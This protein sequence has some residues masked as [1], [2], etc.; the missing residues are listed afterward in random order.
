M[1]SARKPDED[2]KGPLKAKGST[3][4]KQISK[5]RVFRSNCTNSIL[6]RDVQEHLGS[7]I[8]TRAVPALYTVVF[9]LGLPANGLA[10]WVLLFRT[11][12]MPSTMLLVNLVAADLLFML[13]LPFKIT[14]H[15]MENNWIFGEALCRIITAVFYLNMYC[16]VLFLTA[17][18]IDR[19]IGL[20]HPFH[21]KGLRDWRRSTCA[22][23]GIWLVAIAAATVFCLVP[24]TKCFQKPF[25]ITCHEIWASCGGY[26][27][28]TGYF[29]GLSTVGFAI[30]SVAIVF[31]YV[32]ILVS[33]AKK[34]NSYR[35]LIGLIS[36]VLLTFVLCFTPSNVLLFL[37][38]LETSWERHN[39]LYLWY[40]VALSLTSLNSCIDPFIYC[41]ASNDFWTALKGTLCITKEGSGMSSQ[42]T[43]R[44]KLTSSSEKDVLRTGE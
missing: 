38:Y 5:L 40:M 8:T 29:L 36:L 20:V 44:S 13:A 41:Y 26:D 21:A 25:R 15:F 10:L 2:N 23:V 31:C 27:W 33:F 28:Y 14:Y 6:D 12:K 32:F 37:H 24:Q 7:T 30:P 34:K 9:L 4:V 22:S 35:R 17:I 18:S 1:T 3:E 11:K 42:G 16:S 43:K 19:Y 39:Q